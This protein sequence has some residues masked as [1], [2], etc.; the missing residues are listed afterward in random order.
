MTQ[1][2]TKE[3]ELQS[4]ILIDAIT[5][6]EVKIARVGQKLILMSLAIVRRPIMRLVMGHL[7]RD[8]TGQ[9]VWGTNTWHTRQ[10][11]TDLRE[12]QLIRF[13]FQFDCNL[14]QGS[15]GVTY[16]LVSTDTRHEDNYDSVDNYLI[17][18]VV[19]IDLPVFVG[20]TWLNATVSTEVV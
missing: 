7:L 2:G 6:E 5:G 17:F 20:T 1:S 3:V 19:N 16:N 10:V 12:G 13:R 11:L 14:G 8:R 9:I 15:Y 18:D 4:L